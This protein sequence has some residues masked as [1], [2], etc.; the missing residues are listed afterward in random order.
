MK[1]KINIGFFVSL[2]VYLIPFVIS[3]IFYNQ[4][5]EQIA[6]HFG[7]DG[8]HTGYAPKFSLRSGCL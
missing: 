2:A 6:I 8:T 1:K 3:A 4:L 5:P 7:F